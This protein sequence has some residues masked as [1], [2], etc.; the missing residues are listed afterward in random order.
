MSA[1]AAFSG[2]F[3]SAA[4]GLTLYRLEL[5]D[6]EPSKNNT[7]TTSPAPLSRVACCLVVIIYFYYETG[8]CSSSTPAA[9]T[10]GMSASAD[11]M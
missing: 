3:L 10:Q 7:A 11:A 8:R 1:L 2:I 9:D 4:G 5:Q 6:A